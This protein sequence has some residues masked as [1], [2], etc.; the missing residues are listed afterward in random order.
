M[1]HPEMGLNF[2]DFMARRNSK[3]RTASELAKLNKEQLTEEWLKE[4]KRLE[5]KD[6][7]SLTD[8]EKNHL[9]LAI[10]YTS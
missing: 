3:K 4:R 2:L 1:K 10:F 6:P 9:I 5:A 8:N 7:N